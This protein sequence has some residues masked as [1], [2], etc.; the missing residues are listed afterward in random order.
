MNEVI[1]K[2]VT[3]FERRGGEKYADEGV[4]QLEH[5]LQC[6]YL[7]RQQQASSTLE[8]AAL[9]H[10][11][12]HL[13]HGSELP[14]DCHADLDDRHEDIGYSFLRHNF[15]EAVSD[16]VRLHVAAKRYLCTKNR[17]YQQKLSPTS[18]KSFLDQGGVMSDAELADFES[19]TYFHDAVRLREWDDLA[20]DPE[21][22]VP[23]IHDY[24][25]KMESLILT[26]Q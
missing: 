18:Y 23:A 9:L 24:L 12:G 25:P 22:V 11:V 21:L 15:G 14:A 7:A 13:L 16:P 1:E 5:A 26:A 2:I 3:L 4:S 20:K 8:I 19:E 10:D 6:A 17:E